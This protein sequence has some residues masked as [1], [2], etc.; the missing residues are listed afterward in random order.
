[1]KK[2]LSTLL[3]LALV[4]AIAGCNPNRGG[5]GGGGGGGEG[6]ATDTDVT[7]MLPFQKG[8]SFWSEMAPEELGYYKAEGLKVTIQPSGG[9]TEALQQLLTGNVDMAMVAP[10]VIL[11]A[12]AQ[13]KQV[14]VPYTD[15]HS[16]LFSIV[17]PESSDIRSP[18]DLRGKTVGITD[19]GGGEMPIVR[20]ILGKAGLKE[21]TDTK[22]VAVGEGNPTVAKAIRDGRVQ[23]YGASWSDFI[24]IM[25]L[26][27]KLREVTFPEIQKLPSEVLAVRPEYFKDNRETVEKV[28]RSM[29]KASYFVTQFP[30][31]WLGML[32]K[33]APQDV[34]DPALAQ[35]GMRIWLQIAAYPKNG[36]GD[37][38]F[39][40]NEPAAWE[41][42]EQIARDYSGGAGKP[43]ADVDVRS[44]VD[45]S[46][47][48]KVN[49]FPRDEIKRQG[50]ALDLSF[51]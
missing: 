21:G 13:G 25:G 51:P 44:I 39:G 23:A 17:V 2:G 30:D 5:G 1:M 7:L 3:G 18:A 41:Q 4:L 42:L 36:Q 11:E 35:L 27:M 22:L 49:D 37:Y 40:Q 45:D 38:V 14:V 31:K 8:L 6:G 19:F 16:G 28:A 47:I 50:E 10:A 12:V 26:G 32:K 48:Q 20:A 9:G 43:R 15:K 24:P 33:L 29:A 34:A 46:L